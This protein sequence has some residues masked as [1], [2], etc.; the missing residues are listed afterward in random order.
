MQSDKIPL[1]LSREGNNGG[2]KWRYFSSETV[3]F[4]VGDTGI[5]PVTSSVSGKRATAVPI[6]HIELSEV[7]TSRP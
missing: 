1:H 5:E 2:T 7:A 6:A 3:Y 4:L